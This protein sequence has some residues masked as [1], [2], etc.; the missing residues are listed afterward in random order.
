LVAKTR[1]E[2]GQA[3]RFSDNY[4]TVYKSPDPFPPE[5]WRELTWCQ[6]VQLS[7]AGAGG[8]S[9]LGGQYSFRLNSLFDPDITGGAHQ[10]YG[11]D[12]MK[13]LYDKYIVDATEVELI[14]QAPQG[15]QP[16]C[17]VWSVAPH[18]SVY[19]LTGR[20]V[21]DIMEQTQG[22][23]MFLDTTGITAKRK[24]SVKMSTIE[25]IT[26]LQYDDELDDYSALV[27]ANPTNQPYMNLA[28]ANTLNTTAITLPVFVLIRFRAKFFS[29]TIQNP[30]P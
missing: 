2:V 29:R 5:M 21:S 18:T 9:V 25:G 24:F 12:Q 14:I 13:V 17:L 6:S 3:L 7:A 27:S 26:K 19:S 22:S 16:A 28:L 23:Y 11:Y 8:A 15:V 4:M 10:P 30:S 20:N 1:T